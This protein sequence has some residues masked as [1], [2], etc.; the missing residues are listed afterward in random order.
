MLR[1]SLSWGSV[2]ELYF[3]SKRAMPSAFAVAAIRRATVSGAPT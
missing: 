1:I 2:P 3:M